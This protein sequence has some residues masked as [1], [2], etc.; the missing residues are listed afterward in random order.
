MAVASQTLWFIGLLA[1]A[2]I[3]RTVFTASVKHAYSYFRN[4]SKR[5]PLH[6][7]YFTCR[8]ATITAPGNM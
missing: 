5:D 4:T 7:V 2:I 8:Y 3:M 6:W 1:L